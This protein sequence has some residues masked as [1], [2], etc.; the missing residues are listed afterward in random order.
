[1]AYIVTRQS[2]YPQA[3]VLCTGTFNVM[4]AG[5]VELLEFASKH[6]K[7]T[8][9][10]NGDEYLQ[11]K[12]GTYAI[13]LLQRA[14]VLRSC[15]YVD[16]VVFFNEDDPSALIRKLRPRYFVRGPDYLGKILP[17]QDALEAVG[18]ILLLHNV[19]KINSS[20]MIALGAKPVGP[21]S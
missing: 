20:S 18:T 10:I 16:K 6:G 14:Y 13:P 7:V 19:Q 5:H 4:H 11:K 8:V 12:Y 2:L 15:R 17:E 3:E 21:V 1:M 9:G